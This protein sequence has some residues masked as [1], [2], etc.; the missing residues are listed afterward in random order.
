MYA[1]RI[2]IV[3]RLLCATKQND[4]ELHLASVEAMLP[5]IHVANQQNYAR[6]A[7][8]YFLTMLNLEDNY[9]GAEKW[10]RD[11]GFSVARSNIPASHVS[12]DQA[13][14]QSV[15]REAKGKSDITGF[16][17]KVSAYIGWCVT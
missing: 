13:L 5:I 15:N 11:G 8:V 14:E 4:L 12:V 1:E 2:W 17:P 16:S 7:T 6:Y 10:L 9:P 3:L